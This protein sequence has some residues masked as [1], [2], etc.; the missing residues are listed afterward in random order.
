M[1]AKICLTASAFLF[2][3]GKVLLVKHQK[4]QQWLGPGGHIDENELPHEA[5][6]REFLEETGLKVKVYSA[7]QEFAVSANAEDL[8]HPI[9]MAINEHWVCHENYQA[10]L[11]AQSNKQAF[12]PHA[13]WSKGCE[14]HLNFAY[15]ARLDGPLEIK[16]QAGESEEIAWFTLEELQQLSSQDLASSIL[17]E[18]TRAFELVNSDQT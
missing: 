7:A 4:L 17:V 5:A 1:K 11:E 12:T 16:P 6:E 8:F 9:P 3:Q 13:K 18:V 15:L 10:R 2:H 14:K